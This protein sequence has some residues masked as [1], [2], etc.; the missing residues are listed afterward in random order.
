[1]GRTRQQE[2]DNRRRREEGIQRDFTDFIYHSFLYYELDS[3]KISDSRF[4]GICQS[5]QKHWKQVKH[6][7][8]HLVTPEDLAAGTGCGLSGR[9]PQWVFDRAKAE[10]V[11]HWMLGNE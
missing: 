9:Y 6:P 3:P 7:D 5:L 10:G 4:D 11:K 1:M 8:K 2:L